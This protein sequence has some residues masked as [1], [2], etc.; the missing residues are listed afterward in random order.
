MKMETA[1]FHE[2]TG[3]MI[4]SI[5]LAYEDLVAAYDPDDIMATADELMDALRGH[6][7][8]L[9]NEI[10]FPTDSAPLDGGEIYD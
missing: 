4:K 2:L 10:E 5:G 8:E 1:R 3:D 7:E 9:N 6:I